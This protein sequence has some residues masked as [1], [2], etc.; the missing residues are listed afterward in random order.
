MHPRSPIRVFCLGGNR[1]RLFVGLCAGLIVMLALLVSITSLALAASSFPDV[2]STHPYC[3]AIT[4]LADRDIVNGKTDGKFYPG[5]L[6]TRQQFAK[7]IVGAGGYPVSESDICP[8]SDVTKGDDTTFYPDNFVAVCAAKGI[9]TGK[10]ATTF[11]PLG[12]I[13]RYQV[14]TMVV[15]A[16][17][18][19]QPGLLTTP[20]TGW[21]GN[22]TWVG[23]RT[24]GTN[25]ARAE[26]NGL[27]AGF[28]L[29]ALDPY[30][31]MNR[32]EVA[33]VLHNLLGKLTPTSTTTT[34][35]TQEH[36]LEFVS[37]SLRA[38]HSFGVL[39]IYGKVRNIGHVPLRFVKLR[40]T[41]L[42]AS[43]E[44][45]STRAFYIQSDVLAPGATSNFAVHI[46]D[47]D[48][49]AARYELNLES[50]KY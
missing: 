43:D 1:R 15:R 8:F 25:A 11:D 48:H 10:T 17:D 12:N 3:V 16:A 4:D 33:Q 23:N 18:D 49:Q 35:T 45:I 41:V 40:V 28:D 24:H 36:V 2:P 6:V 22:A 50:Y 20:P 7:M 13:T 21:S 19:L 38:E 44:T 14:V 29:S 9:T 27:L 31:N 34:V 32:G 37:G 5:D 26:H 46:A 47:R 42:D 30:G 39:S